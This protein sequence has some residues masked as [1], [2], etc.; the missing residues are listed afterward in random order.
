MV[1]LFGCCLETVFSSPDLLTVFVRTGMMCT[2][3]NCVSNIQSCISSVFA[4]VCG[5][6]ARLIHVLCWLVFLFVCLSFAMVSL[7]ASRRW[8]L[9]VHVV[10]SC[11]APST[12]ARLAASLLAPGDAVRLQVI[13]MSATL[14]NVHVLADWLG[15]HLH[16][17]DHR[18][19]PLTMTVASKSETVSSGSTQSSSLQRSQLAVPS[20]STA[21]RSKDPD[22]WV[23]TRC[24]AFNI[25]VHLG[26]PALPPQQATFISLPSSRERPTNPGAQENQFF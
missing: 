5:L 12:E 22:G 7:F 6:F 21:Q 16:I 4:V 15:A 18:P 3:L 1:T 11:S 26:R 20:A 14:P 25:Q 23:C 10:E 19:V 24:Q 17:S 2:C 8:M 13:G 9:T